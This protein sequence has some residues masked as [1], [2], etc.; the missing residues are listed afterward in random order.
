MV[1]LARHP[2]DGDARL[3]A[4]AEA[5]QV[6]Q[7]GHGAA[8]VAH[9]VAV[10]GLGR[11]GRGGPAVPDLHGLA[12]RVFVGEV[13]VGEL[14]ARV[15]LHHQLAPLA[16][17]RRFGHPALDVVDVRHDGLLAVLAGILGEP[18]LALGEVDAGVL[19]HHPVGAVGHQHEVERVTEA[20]DLHGD[21]R[22]RPEGFAGVDDRGAGGR[23]RGERGL[24]G[25][26]CLPGADCGA[27]EHIAERAG[28]EQEH[29]AQ[30]CHAASP[31]TVCST[32]SAMSWGTSSR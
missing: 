15:V 22:V 30:N 16:G 24:E 17:N 19:V 13:E 7:G 5:V 9:G 8:A 6:E 18:E 28:A 20:P 14:R 10:A 2:V 23:A 4:D 32:G 29:Q 21:H 25:G 1:Q 31:T 11:L 3:A 26:A 12:Q 27:G